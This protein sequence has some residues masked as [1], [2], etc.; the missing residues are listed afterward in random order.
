M[1]ATTGPE[2]D[3]HVL[4]NGDWGAAG[5]LPAGAPG[6]P[7]HVSSGD[8]PNVAFATSIVDEGLVSH[9]GKYVISSVGYEGQ[10][11]VW[12]F[13]LAQLDAAGNA[14]D[15]GAAG[16]PQPHVSMLVPDPPVAGAPLQVHLSWDAPI[17]RDDC[18][19]GN[20]LGTCTD[21][22]PAPGDPDGARAGILSASNIYRIESSCA[23][24]P[25][26]SRL[27]AWGSP[28]AGGPGGATS[29]MDTIPSFNPASCYY[30][31]LGLAG[32]GH[33]GAVSAHTTVGTGDRDGDGVSDTLDNCPDDA[34]AGQTNSDGDFPGDACDNCPTV[35][36]SDQTDGDGDGD[37]DACDN[38]RSVSN[39][40]QANNDADT[41][42]D[43]CDNCPNAT[44]ENQADSDFDA[45]GDACDNCAAISNS[46]Q[47]DADGDG[48]G[49]V[50]DNCPND[51]NADQAD[52]EGDGFGDAC[53]N[54]P[55]DSNPDQSDVDI[56]GF[57]DV[58]D[59]CPVIPNPTQDPNACLQDVIDLVIDFKQKAAL[60]KWNTTTETDIDY[61]NVVKI[62][63]GVPQV[64]NMLPI[65]CQ[66]C[67]DGR[68]GSYSFR[69]PNHK[70][71][72]SFRVQLVKTNG[73]IVT[74][75][76]PELDNTPQ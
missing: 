58:C 74:Y 54:C 39:A 68:P 66:A 31:T 28:V 11:G 44:N 15:L 67:E 22:S 37:G 61:F 6:C 29:A 24:P 30:Y 36:N 26:S 41:L 73:D 46:S 62:V 25:T 38:C 14:V 35:T 1:A 20:T 5:V 23:T 33:V 18:F 56:D 48:D 27:S 63:K 69:I 57:G 65:P 45:I 16:I 49:D 52:I 3:G 55:T 72:Q 76:P 64:L 21:A 4:V 71:Y 70:S 7:V 34:N 59:T 9:Q 60:L 32:G 42:G 17:L 10:A 53:D 40:S 12:L 2:P 43:A 8:S 47:A 19:A 50:C 75:G 13:D 51:S